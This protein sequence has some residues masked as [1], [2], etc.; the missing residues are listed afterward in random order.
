MTT[1]VYELADVYTAGPVCIDE[2]VT[3]MGQYDDTRWN[4]WLCPRIDAWA[5]EKVLAAF[6]RDDLSD[7]YPPTHGWRADGALVVTEWDGEDPYTAVLLPDEDGLYAL[8]AWA[9]VWAPDTDEGAAT[10]ALEDEEK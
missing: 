6:D 7:Q 1:E 5:V 9:W 2:V 4:G 3:V 10:A 8:G